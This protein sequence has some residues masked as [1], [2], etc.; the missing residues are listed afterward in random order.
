MT[1]DVSGPPL[2]NWKFGETED[3]LLPSDSRGSL[4]DLNADGV[5]N[6]RPPVVVGGVTGYSRLFDGAT[7]T[8]LEVQDLGDNVRLDRSMT[9]QAL[10]RLDLDAQD[11][12]AVPGSVVSYG[13]RDAAGGELQFLL[14]LES[15]ST[16][17]RETRIKMRWEDS[18]GVLEGT[19]VGAT[20]FLPASGAQD[21]V[22]L[23][24]ASRRWISDTEVI[25]SYYVNDQLIGTDTSLVGDI[26]TGVT[27]ARMLVGVRGDGASAYENYL[28]GQI[29]A[30]ALFARTMSAEEIRQ[31]YN[32]VSLHGADGYSI[33][34]ASLPED[35]YST[36]EDS[37]IQ[38]ELFVEG[39]VFGVTLSKIAEF[40]EDLLPDRAWSTLED[41]EEMTGLPPKAAD[42]IEVRRNRILS[43][44]RAVQGYTV[45]NVKDAL[46]ATFD[47]DESDI[48]IVEYSHFQTDGF[49]TVIDPFWQEIALSGT[50]AIVA[51]ELVITSPTPAPAGERFWLNQTA[52]TG[53]PYVKTS[54]DGDARDADQSI[55]AEASV[56]ITAHTFAAVDEV[57]SGY[58]FID[59][60]LNRVTFIGLYDGGGGIEIASM[61]V[62]DGV[63]SAV[64]THGLPPA[65]PFFLNVKFTGGTSYEISTALAAD[66]TIL[67]AVATIVGTPI[68]AM[69]ALGVF[70]TSGGGTA[71]D[72]TLDDFQLYTRLGLRVFNWYAF[73]DPILPGDEDIPGANAVVK[74][75]K[76]AHTHAA[77]V[78]TKAIEW[79]SPDS[80]FD[81]G[82]LEGG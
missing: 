23:F 29:E 42:S 82:P 63:Q 40:R 57:I 55:S 38:L 53:P 69:L 10:V 54:I 17:T 2:V 58:A 4:E 51:G 65:L 80:L 31:T 45:Q 14:E 11:A 52:T 7:P 60:T 49:A 8:G 41:W 33:V 6:S 36:D 72:I 67:T 78:S 56:L 21:A 12:A 34:K 43:F 59:Q 35:V 25:V 75:I 74:K 61:T 27:G 1:L 48:E 77:A 19:N 79:D 16:I 62:E 44:L 30:M 39:Q 46:E 13:F 3:E 28:E 26:G 81:D 22:L 76:P 15:V 64:A 5:T 20:F 37:V 71:N 18:V 50:L 73:R 32:A 70:G 68:P 9:V 66:R 47:L 24:T